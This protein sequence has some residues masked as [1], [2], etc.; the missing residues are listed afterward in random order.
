MS[1][2]LGSL[3]SFPRPFSTLRCSRCAV[4][5]ELNHPH[6]CVLLPRLVL[7]FSMIIANR[8]VAPD[9]WR[10]LIAHETEV[11]QRR[12][13]PPRHYPEEPSLAAGLDLGTRWPRW[14]GARG[15]G[16]VARREWRGCVIACVEGV[17]AM[18]ERCLHVGCGGCGRHSCITGGEMAN[19]PLAGRASGSIASMLDSHPC[20]NQPPGPRLKA[21]FIRST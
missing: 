9:L 13:P 3:T 12:A 10:G 2:F 14:T 7:K 19:V 15:V 4:W 5:R 17:E 6:F 11:T 1:Q 20:P 16:S 8:Y 21:I 18:E